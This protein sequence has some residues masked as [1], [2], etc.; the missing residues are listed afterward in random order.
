MAKKSD[1]KESN[2]GFALGRENYIVSDCWICN[3]SNRL[4]AY[5]RR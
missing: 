5:D 3:Y 1:V 2:P 4:F